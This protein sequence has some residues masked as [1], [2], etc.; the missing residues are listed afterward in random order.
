MSSRRLLPQVLVFVSEFAHGF[1]RFP[2]WFLQPCTSTNI[3]VA[4][5]VSSQEDLRSLGVERLG[6][7]AQSGRLQPKLSCPWTRPRA[8]LPGLHRV[9]GRS[10]VGKQS[11]MPRRGKTKLLPLPEP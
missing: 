3:S 7:K 2:G 10:R 1:N 6:P 8:Q 5:P 11:K 9:V 4:N